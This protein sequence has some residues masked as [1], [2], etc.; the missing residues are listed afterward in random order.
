MSFVQRELDKIS[1]ALRDPSAAEV[2]DKLYAAQQALSWALEPGAFK[3]P[4]QT[5]MGIP[6]DSEGYSRPVHLPHVPADE[7]KN[8]ADLT[9]EEIDAKLAATEARIETKL[10]ALE[11]KFD[12]IAT[13]ID[14][15][16]NQIATS[17]VAI[18]KTADRS[19]EAANRAEEI[20]RSTR[21]NMVFLSLAVVASVIATLA[22]G[23]QMFDVA[24]NLI[25]AVQNR[26]STMQ[27]G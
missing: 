12:L 25:Q 17:Q 22:F 21:W 26:I 14:Y 18:Q 24:T 20:T 3:P 15:A 7:I 2:H 1:A 8:M 4:Y 11:S 5:V 23:A 19:E 9:R 16:I 13:K 10:T 6:G 27:S